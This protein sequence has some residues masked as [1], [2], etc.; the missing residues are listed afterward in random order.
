MSEPLV[1]KTIEEFRAFVEK[2]G[3]YEL[4]SRDAKKKYKTFF[5]FSFDEIQQSEGKEVAEKVL[6]AIKNNTDVLKNGIGKLDN[7]AKFQQLGLVLNGMNLCA[8]CVGFIIMCKKLEDMSATIEQQISE[9]K[10]KIEKSN[11]V[12][13]NYKFNDVLEDHIDMLD[14]RKKQKPYSEEKMRELVS[15]ESVILNYLIDVLNYDISSNK[16]AL[17]FSLMSMASMFTASLKYYDEIY[18]FNYN[19]LHSSHKHWMEVYTKLY[20]EPVIKKVQE[21]GFLDMELS[22]VLTDELYIS[23]ED[24]VKELE[25]EIEDNLKLLKLTGNEEAFKSFNDL[26]GQ[27]LK[28]ELENAFKTA[29]EQ[30]PN[31]KKA[32]DDAINQVCQ[33]A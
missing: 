28:A 5:K 11:D 1:I 23:F 32:Y 25:Q 18:Y 27:A 6:D 3:I 8:T 24:Q 16:E 33:V 2:N 21:C 31:T 4:V 29:F 19:D 9:V 22:T 17:I 7:L 14:C 15:R 13:L 10:Q 30:N 20:S 26:S 12:Q